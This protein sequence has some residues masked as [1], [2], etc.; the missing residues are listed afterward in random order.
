MSKTAW[1]AYLGLSFLNSKIGITNV[2]YKIDTKYCPTAFVQ[3]YNLH[4]YLTLHS[5]PPFAT[6]LKIISLTFICTAINEGSRR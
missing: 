3:I 4:S 2:G 5:P 1:K 6:K